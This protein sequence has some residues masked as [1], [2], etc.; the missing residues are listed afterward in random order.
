MLRG[1]FE[2]MRL[3]HSLSPDFVVKPLEWGACSSAPNVYFYIS[4]FH[5]F[6]DEKVD[7]EVFCSRAA[8]LHHNSATEFENERVATPVE[9]RFGFHVTTHMGILSHDNR[10]TSTW[11]EFYCKEFRR[12]LAFEERAQGPSAELAM[13]GQQLLDNVIPRLLRPLETDGRSIRPTLIHGDLHC[14]NVRVDALTQ[15]PIFFDAGSFWGHNECTRLGD[16]GLDAGLPT[17]MN[18]VIY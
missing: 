13:L 9:G 18:K 12:A 1:E 17:T 7:L 4:E 6:L 2:S 11:E 8:D 5:D 3:L 14:R 10:W 15:K 16:T